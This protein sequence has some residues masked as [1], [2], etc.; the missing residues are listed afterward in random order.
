MSTL[1][2]LEHNLEAAIAEQQA[3]RVTREQCI[4]AMDKAYGAG[5]PPAEYEG[6]MEAAL[7]AAIASGYVVINRP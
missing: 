7:N 6:D 4:K 2:R 1:D 3:G 5:E